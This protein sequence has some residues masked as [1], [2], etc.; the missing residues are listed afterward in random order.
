[1]FTILYLKWQ[2]PTYA[3]KVSAY[4]FSQNGKF[5]AFHVATERAS[6]RLTDS[7]HEFI[8]ETVGSRQS[9]I[10]MYKITF[11]EITFVA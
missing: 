8:M 6:E 1:M 3:V 10:Q 4:S 2:H 9:L 11:L 7:T 5:Q